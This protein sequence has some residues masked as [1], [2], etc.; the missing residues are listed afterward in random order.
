MSLQLVDPPYYL[1]LQDMIGN[2]SAKGGRK[3]TDRILIDTQ[4]LVHISS[5]TY[6]KEMNILLGLNLRIDGLKDDDLV[7]YFVEGRY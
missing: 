4:L 3:E 1:D 5:I 6:C 2:N 7:T